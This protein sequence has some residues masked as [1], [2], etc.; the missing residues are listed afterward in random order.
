[1]K[2]EILILVET[3]L[4]GRCGISLPNY[5]NISYCNRQRGKG[6]GLIIAVREDS[7]ICMIVTDI[8]VEKEQ[9]W[10][11]IQNANMS[12]NLGIMYGLH[13]TRC[14]DEEIDEWFFKLESSISKWVDE[15]VIIVG[16][17]NAHIGNDG[18]GIEGNNSDINKN[19][20]WWRSIIE[21]RN[22]ILINGTDLCCGKW[23][24]NAS[25]GKNSILDLVLCN[26]KMNNTVKSMQI[27]EVGKWKISRFSKVNGEI[28]ET[29]S[30]HNSILVELALP[31]QASIKKGK[32]WRMTEESLAEFQNYTNHH[33][34]KEKWNS[35][36]DVNVKYKKWIKEVKTLMYKHFNRATKKSKPQSKI[37]KNKIKVKNK[38][39][40]EITNLKKDNRCEG[41]Y[42][43]RLK[44]KL[45]EV[46]TEI[47]VEIDKEKKEKITSRMQRIIEKQTTSTNE[48]WKVRSNII[49]RPDIKVAVED[50]E[51]KLLTNK[52]DILLRHNEYYQTLLT[53]RKPEPEAEDINKEIEDKFQLNMEND[54]H[55]SEP[56]NAPFTASELDTVIKNLRTKKCPGRDE[57]TSDLLKYAGKELKSSMLKMFNWFWMN[58]DIPDE[59]Q[60]IHIKSIYKGKGKTSALSNHRGIFLSSEILKLYE[61][62]IYNRS[63]PKIERELSEYQAGGRI[64]RNI[65]DHVFI[66][67]SIMQHYKYINKYL[68]L[69]FLDLI[70]AFDKMSLKH[71]LNDLWRCNVRGKIWRNIYIINKQSSVAIKTAMGDSP[72]FEIGETLKQGSVLAT[73]LASMHTDGI[74]KLFSHEALGI[75]YGDLRIN[76]LIFQDDIIKLENSI[77]NLNKSNKII[78]T[79][80]Q[81]NLMEFH[82]DKSQVLETQASNKSVTL[83]Q[84]TLKETESYKYL[85]D[86]IT[87]DGTLKETIEDRSK[88]CTATVAELNSIIEE[89]VSENIL[90]DA[91]I[92]YQNSIII[93][94]LCLNSESWTLNNTELQSMERIHN[95]SLKRML[96][97]PQGTPSFGLRAELGILSVESIIHRRKLMFLHR[98]LSQP[99]DNI[100][101]QVMMQQFHLP[102][103]T[104]LN[105]TLALCRKIGLSEDLEIIKNTPKSAWKIMINTAT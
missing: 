15:P 63:T 24:R 80:Q 78:T 31:S 14:S 19:G 85:G 39:S 54:E 11:K 71:V 38:I 41:E 1:M 79:Y 9:M 64:K 3:H 104:W 91:V 100:T 4:T 35:K 16:D 81:M 84:I 87:A 8:D 27:D 60:R 32:V 57:V 77:H 83:G 67:R 7:D 69:E 28:K 10:V 51:G 58:E 44:E 20:K 21:R 86:I 53:T 92:T 98:L 89:T 33:E 37:I 17:M 105:N 72:D 30:D 40:K 55:D 29:P 99:D 82:R 42:V 34:M 25:D 70:K 90:I 93:P 23:T 96:R 94:K 47:G 74:T 2:P 18:S 76:C 62:L 5:K 36:G 101:R 13:E 22:L 97:L 65:T 12:F 52:D 75:M 59:L 43:N 48:I 6:G 56:I 46:L 102:G 26:E 61:K 68:V 50:D 73:A 103:E 66:L 88:S 45:Q 49:K 95:K